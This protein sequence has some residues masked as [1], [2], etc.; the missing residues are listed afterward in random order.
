MSL[1]SVT[2]TYKGHMDNNALL[3]IC[4]QEREPPQSAFAVIIVPNAAFHRINGKNDVTNCLTLAFLAR[5][6]TLHACMCVW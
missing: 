2:A 6:H 1:L 3:H 5:W 4:A